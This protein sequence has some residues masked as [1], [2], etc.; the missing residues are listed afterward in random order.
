MAAAPDSTNGVGWQGI[1]TVAIALY[2]AGLSTYLAVVKLLSMR[3]RVTVKVSWGFRTMGP[4]LSDYMVFVTVANPGERNVRVHAPGLLLPDGRSFCFPVPDS[5]VSY[6]HDL[7][8]GTSCMMWI[9]ERE[10]AAQLIANGFMGKVKL[11]AFC[12][13]AVGKRYKSR[14]FWCDVDRLLSQGG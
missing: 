3:R 2:A 1:A 4:E 7:P 12:H 6:P 8:E 11:V 13:D 10:L 14:R 5:D 9:P